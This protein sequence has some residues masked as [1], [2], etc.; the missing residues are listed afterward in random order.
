MQRLWKGALCAL[1]L[2]LPLAALATGPTGS[3]RGTVVDRHG[4]PVPGASLRLSGPALPHALRTASDLKGAFLFASVPEGK[5]YELHVSAVG[6]TRLGLRGVAVSGGRETKLS[7][8]LSSG[9]TSVTS[10]VRTQKGAR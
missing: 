1:L 7:V 3:V 8:Q 4:Q 9:E 2:C 10:V 5:G 6:Y